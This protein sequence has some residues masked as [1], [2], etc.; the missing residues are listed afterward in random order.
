VAGCCENGGESVG[1]KVGEFP[2]QLSDNET[3]EVSI[4]WGH[5]ELICQ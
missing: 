5:L 1:S 3:F 4:V 2:S